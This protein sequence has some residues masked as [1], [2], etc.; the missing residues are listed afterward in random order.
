MS[1]DGYFEDDLDPAF[2]Q[3]VD[4]IEAAYVAS[5]M[6]S[7][8]ILASAPASK[9]PPSK[10]RDVI[11]IDDDDD[12]DVSDDSY[13]AFD[14]DEEQLKHF[15][16]VCNV[17]I[18]TPS[19]S[20]KP[21][22]QWNSKGTVQT[23]TLFDEIAVQKI[24]T[25]KSNTSSAQITMSGSGIRIGRP[26]RTKQWDRTAS[27]KTDWK[28]PKGKVKASLCE[29]EEKDEEWEEPVEFEQFPTPEVD[30]GYVLSLTISGRPDTNHKLPSVL[31]VCLLL[32]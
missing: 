4:A 17:Q 2:L 18:S 13:A 23:T 9:Q 1:S 16:E 32:S 15:D 3:Q 10:H 12:D 29:E 27:A 31:F 26:K 22:S 28:K 19:T 8:S 6:A 24:P 20:K 5:H 21:I 7:P 14:I 25:S 30:L 11:E